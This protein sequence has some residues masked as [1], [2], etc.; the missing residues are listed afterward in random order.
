[1]Q[2]PI[3]FTGLS[4]RVLADPPSVRRI[5]AGNTYS[6]AGVDY[7]VN[8]IQAV[9]V[10]ASFRATYYL[11]FEGR[12]TIM[13]SPD[14]DVMAI[15]TALNSL[16]ADGQT[17]FAVTNP[18]PYNAYVEFKGPLAGQPQDLLVAEVGNVEPGDLTFSLDLNTAEVFAALRDAPTVSAQF[19]VELE[20]A[21][22]DDLPE[23]PGRIITLFRESV[24]IIRELQWEEMAAAAGIDWL[25][26]PQPRDSTAPLRASS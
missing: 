9:K 21:N 2:A 7:I 10:P 15:E 20:I 13:F 14:D 11:K 22:D 6:E 19:E 25:R 4:E 26:P 23:T 17:R 18:Q 1:M 16:F 24:T 5:R 12:A 3:A 8:E